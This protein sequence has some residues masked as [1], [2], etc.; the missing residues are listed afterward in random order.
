MA[1]NA[2]A[3]NRSSGGCGDRTNTWLLREAVDGAGD[4]VQV[5]VEEARAR[6]QTGHRAHLADLNH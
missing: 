6:G 1:G 3:R 4:G 5:D 2:F